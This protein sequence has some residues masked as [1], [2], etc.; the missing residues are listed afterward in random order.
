MET[1]LADKVL[2]GNR[3]SLARLITLVENEK[4]SIRGE[5]AALYPHTGKAHIIGVTGAAG[6]GKSTLVNEIAKQLRKEDRTVGIIAVDP[7]SPFSGGAVLGDRIRMR[8]LA[9]DDGIFI[10]SMASRGSLGGLA[11]TT[12]EIVKILD[13]FGFD[14]VIVE[15]V[16]AGQSEVEIAKTAHTT[17]VIQAPGMGDDIQ[18]IKA[19][20]LEIADIL[21]VNKADRPGAENT[22]RA[23]QMMQRL[24][25]NGSTINRQQAPFWRYREEIRLE[26]INKKTTSNNDIISWEPPILQTNSIDGTGIVEVSASIHAHRSYLDETG[27][28][29]VREATRIGQQFEILLRDALVGDLLKRISVGKLDKMLERVI[30]REI[31]PYSA[32]DELID[33]AAKKSTVNS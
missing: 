11:R 30:A 8:D 23:L 33:E 15:T 26:S 13:A 18:A 12:G 22:V 10:R 19:G 6:S 17:L 7:T 5:L 3:R 31:D 21:I 25:K 4:S 29:R 1:E 32:V 14:I 28:F 2:S 16:G 20:I 24:S 9:G 27:L